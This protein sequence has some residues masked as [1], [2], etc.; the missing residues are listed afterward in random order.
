MKKL[1]FLAAFLCAAVPA[2]AAPKAVIRLNEEPWYTEK[3]GKGGFRPITM[4]HGFAPFPV[5]FEGW[6]STPREDLKSYQWDFGDGS[7]P[8]EGFC[9]AHVYEKPGT[10]TARLTVVDKAGRQ[11]S[12]SVEISVIAHDWKTYYVDAENGDD[13][14]D[15]LSKETPWKTATWAFLG[16]N[17]KRYRSAAQVLFKRGG[18]YPLESGVVKPQH[19][20]SGYGHLFGAYGEGPKPVIKHVTDPKHP[21][22]ADKQLFFIQGIDNLPHTAFVDLAFD[23]KADT[24]E[25]SGVYVHHG[26]V[27]NVLFLRCDFSNHHQA[28]VMNGQTEK[29]SIAGVFIDRCTFRDSTNVHVFGKAKR[30]ALMNSE[31]EAGGNHGAYLSWI[32]GGYIAGNTFVQDRKER[33]ALRLSG[34][35]DDFDN[36]TRNVVIRDN[37]ILGRAAPGQRLPWVLV[38]IAPNV[39]KPQSIEWVDFSNNEVRDGENLLFVTSA[40]N[41]FVRDNVFSTRDAT[42]A[43]IRFSI[44]PRYGSR[45]CKNV[46]FTGNDIEVNCG[47]DDATARIFG[48]HAYKGPPFRGQVEHEG[49]HIVDNDIRMVG[50]RGSALWFEGQKAALISGVEFRNRIE[51]ADAARDPVIKVGGSY[52]APGKEYTLPAWKSRGK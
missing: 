32:Q 3:A 29:D 12:A 19:Y 1:L 48:V 49:I 26:R 50:G 28:I 30:F 20:S 33:T 22:R 4:T 37:R 24:G 21:E 52:N 11:D 43:S 44:S 51:G 31:L 13:D 36:P 25:V 27:C 18:V 2:F 46:W 39:D 41:V 16:L 5:F 8:A 35:S 15:G 14:N 7:K 45:P 47:I 17:N 42:G 10:Y 40:E 23:G 6:A 34:A 38:E 9:A